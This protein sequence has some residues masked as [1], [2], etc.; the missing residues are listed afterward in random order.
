VGQTDV[1]DDLGDRVVHGG[2]HLL[3]GVSLDVMDTF[4]EGL[5]RSLFVL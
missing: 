2:N 4:L 1:V 5:V 3:L